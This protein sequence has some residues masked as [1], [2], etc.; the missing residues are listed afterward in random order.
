MEL[1]HHP[2]T[3]RDYLHLFLCGIA[4]GTV[5]VIPGVSGGTMAFILGIYE[6]L[7]NA[8]KSFD[9]HVLKLLSRF[10]LKDIF[11]YVPWQFLVAL[12]FGI[13]AAVIT[14]AHAVSWMLDNQPVFLFAFFFGLIVASIVVIGATVIWSPQTIAMLVVGTLLALLVVNLVPLDMPHDPVTLFFSG[15]LAIVA[16]IL[17]GISGSFI[18]L[19]IGQYD[20]ILNAVKSLDILTLL[21][22]GIGAMIGIT[23]FARVLSWLLKRYEQ[24]T[25]ATLVGFMIGSLWKIWP[26]KVVVETR[27]DRH[28]EEIPL[29]ERNILPQFMSAEFGIALVLCIVG[30]LIVYFINRQQTRSAALS[31]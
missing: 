9:L 3:I 8:I 18:L 22:V 28:G 24:G 27:I 30:F 14:L 1:K 7:I 20:Y 26:W 21:P 16:M 17:P 2:R 10:K 13:G 12:F 15:M 23:G 6:D 25:I 29:V 31:H 11:D 19:I 5:D 4:M